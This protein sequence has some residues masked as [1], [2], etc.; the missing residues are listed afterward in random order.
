MCKVLFHQNLKK[1]QKTCLFQR[2]QA[3]TILTRTSHLLDAVL[4]MQLPSLQEK[5][6][7]PI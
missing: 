3:Q 1:K 7:L 6:T 5:I 2:S 4:L